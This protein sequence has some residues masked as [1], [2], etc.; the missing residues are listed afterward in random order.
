MDARVGEV[1]RNYVARGAVIFSNSY[2]SL[3]DYFNPS[4]EKHSALFFGS[5]LV[6]YLLARRIVY[7]LA[8]LT[9]EDCYI[10]E[11]N[12]SGMRAVPLEEFLGTKSSV[13]VYYYMRSVFPA[14]D[15]MEEAIAFAFS[16]ADK[17]YGFGST[18][19][20]CF[21]TVSNCYAQVGV[22]VEPVNLLGREIVLS[23]S[24]TGD[25]RWQKVMD[26]DTGEVVLLA[27]Y[28]Y[29]LKWRIYA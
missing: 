20:Y 6:D 29:Y 16:D 19:S 26:S 22:R 9:N 4:E 1:I 5:G 23:Q 15:V 24:F 13:R 17:D 21:K 25:E 8:G 7:P 10:V 14:L 3:T 27:G 2:G 11:F 18:K 12:V 28:G